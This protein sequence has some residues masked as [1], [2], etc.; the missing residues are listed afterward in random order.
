M[1]G[2][3]SLTRRRRELER[4]ESEEVSTQELEDWERSL[5]SLA[6]PWSV[7]STW[8][9][10][11]IGHFLCLAQ[12]ALNLPE[13]VFYELERCL[14]IPRSSSF[15]SK[16]MTSLLSPP[17]K[18]STLQ[19]RPALPYR[20]WEAELRRR[21]QGWYQ[22][23]GRAEEQVARA[24]HLGLCHQFFWAV[25]E[26]NPLEETPFH[27][28]PFN[29]RV[30]LLKG[31]CDHV[32]ETQKDVQD[33]VLGQPIH[34]CRESV[35][36]YDGRENAYIHFPH[37]CGA[38][39]RIYCQ[40][41]C[42]PMEF[43]LPSFHVKRSEE[44]P[45]SQGSEVKVNELQSVD[46]V[47]VENDSAEVKE[48]EV[49]RSSS[50]CSQHTQDS[51]GVLQVEDLKDV[52]ESS[53]REMRFRV[54]DGCYEGKSPALTSRQ[55][56]QE[57]PPCTE[58]TR[59][60]SHCNHSR[61]E[62][63]RRKRDHSTDETAETRRAKRKKKSELNVRKTNTRKQKNERMKKRVQRASNRTKKHKLS[64]FTFLFN[65]DEIIKGVLVISLTVTHTIAT[66]EQRL[67]TSHGTSSLIAAYLK[68]LNNLI[69]TSYNQLNI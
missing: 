39:L 52:N 25:G 14:L 41:P 29:C 34:E 64:E 10:P 33:A 3:C 28:L 60:C 47:K 32:Y 13:I 24:E 1:C 26:T 49:R 19:R 12:T 20:K 44:E 35:L 65:S 22:T 7:H 53:D 8:E 21:V 30:W 40:T 43:P 2:L 11:A 67:A 27:L 15:L 68:H 69:T 4:K 59:R 56:L 45:R 31:L 48:E 5:L 66:A 9:L 18:R 6:E 36:G 50:I 58:S 16:V 51:G 61:P 55:H 42:L 17:Y 63:N 54:G 57:K 46:S 37:F 62:I 23:V 38:D